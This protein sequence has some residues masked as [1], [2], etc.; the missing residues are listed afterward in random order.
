MTNLNKLPLGLRPHHDGSAIYVPNQAPKLLDK[1]KIRVRI[2]SAIGQVDKVMVRFS[3]SGEAFPTPPAK[4]IKVDGGWTWYEATI[5]MHNPKMHYRFV[6]VLKNGRQLTYN[7]VGLFELE[8][9]DINDFRLNTFSSAP[10]WGPGSIMYQIFPDRWARSAQADKHKTPEWGIAAGWGD[11]VIGQGPGTSEQFF[12]GDLW[13][14]I[15]HLDHLKKLGVTLLYLTPIFPGRSNHRY[16]ASSFAEVDPL[17]GGNKALSALI[18]AAHKK[19]FKI[20]GDLTSNHSG[21]RHEWFTAAYKNPSAPESE[22]YYFTEGNTKY[23]SWFGVPSLPKFNWKSQELRKRFIEGKNSVVAKWLKAPFGF[24]GWRIDVANMTGRIRDEDMYAEVAN[25]VRKT[26]VEVNPDTIMLGEYTGDAA[27]EVQGDGWQGAMTYA[28]FTRPLWRWMFDLSAK[29]NYLQNM[30]YIGRAEKASE[31]VESHVKFA[32]A[33]PWH[34]RLNNMNALNTHDTPRYKSYT[35][36]GAQKVAAGMQFAFP[37]IPVIW[38]GD[39]FGLDG[40]NGEKSRTPIPWNDERPSDKAM[41][42]VYTSLAALRKKH[43]ALVDGSLRFVYADQET[44]IFT[45]ESKRET[46]VVLATRGK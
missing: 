22:F 39:E 2:H 44:V 4:V 23:D 35:L 26:M 24:D 31:F 3:E 21:D 29:E 10:K 45:R 30:G 16:D 14:V 1:V 28:N 32:A 11:E 19:G 38:A 33:F 20:I 7:A 9:P 12:G 40:F 34:V 25:I 13:G 15:E 17:L 27:Y 41:I 18:D 36:P 43:S 37:G 6:I 8:Q 42:E 5:V 46:M